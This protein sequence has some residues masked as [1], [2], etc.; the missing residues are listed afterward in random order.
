VTSF[1]K[2]RLGTLSA[3]IC[4]SIITSGGLLAWGAEPPTE[5]TRLVDASPSLDTLVIRMAASRGLSPLALRQEYER[6]ERSFTTWGTVASRIELAWLLSRPGTGFQDN[7]RAV[8]LLSEYQAQ[9]EADPAFLAFAGMLYDLIIER[10]VQRAASSRAKEQLAAERRQ[11]EALSE[12]IDTLLQVLAT[13][14]AQVDALRDIEKD[15]NQRA[16]PDDTETL[17][18]DDNGESNT[19]G[20]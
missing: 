7:R 15:I 17:L 4:C 12:Q 6:A 13:L 16:T 10:A 2:S 5:S 18:P 8:T 19:P 9:T 3:A 20:G 14:Q 1:R 11:A